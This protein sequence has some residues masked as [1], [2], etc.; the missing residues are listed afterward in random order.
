MAGTSIC[1][2]TE[3]KLVLAVGGGGERQ[4]FSWPFGHSWTPWF[5]F[6]GARQ[7]S[8]RCE[9]HLKP[10]TLKYN[11]FFSDGI[12]EI[13]EGSH[14]KALEHVPFACSE[15][16]IAKLFA[17]QWEKNTKGFLCLILF[18][19]KKSPRTEQQICATVVQ[20]LYS[21]RKRSLQAIC[22]QTVPEEVPLSFQLAHGRK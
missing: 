8:Q 9:D 11:V 20:A 17:C 15:A 3:S 14:V 1:G 7:I 5:G 22:K 6:Q 21:S 10:S 16:V 18:G 12:F 2:M 4:A 13:S 19:L